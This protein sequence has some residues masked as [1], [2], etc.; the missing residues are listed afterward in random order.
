[1]TLNYTIIGKRIKQARKRMKLTQ[2]NLAEKI[3]K[4]PS[5]ISY[6]ENG[7]KQLSLETLVDIANTLQVSADDLLSF[8][9]EYKSE[10]KSE[11]SSILEN[12]S[13]YEKKV[14]TDI[15]KALKQSLR[16]ERITR[17]YY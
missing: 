13:T 15:A 8:N 14:I 1:M 2:E 6:I 16:D 9:I 12:C 7:K 4:C 11:F 3:D 5:Y 10:A 17:T